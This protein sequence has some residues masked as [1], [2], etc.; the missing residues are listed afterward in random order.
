VTT[1]LLRKLEDLEAKV[2]S[3]RQQDRLQRATASGFNHRRN[4]AVRFQ[5]DAG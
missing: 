3:I 5:R 1:E 2:A 4:M